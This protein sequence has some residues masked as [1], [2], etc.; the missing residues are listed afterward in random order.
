MARS[1][2]DEA[3]KPG[4][5]KRSIKKKKTAAVKRTRR[6]SEPA[7][8]FEPEVDGPTLGPVPCSLMPHVLSFCGLRELSK[9][10]LLDRA[11]NAEAMDDKH[12]LDKVSSQQ[13]T[14][15][16]ITSFV[17]MLAVIEVDPI[18]AIGLSTT[19]SDPLLC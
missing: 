1:D 14:V 10:C 8:S 19:L 11:F 18:A 13:S 12:Y 9:L 5:G 4:K 16:C 15:S 3:Y 6:A 17:I 2:G 7:E